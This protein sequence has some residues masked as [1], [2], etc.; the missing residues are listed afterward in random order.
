M[1]RSIKSMIDTDYFVC[2]ISIKLLVRHEL[3]GTIG[4]GKSIACTMEV[5]LPECYCLHC[6]ELVNTI[7]TKHRMQSHVSIQMYCKE[8]LNS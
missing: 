5:G 7:N 6:L 1:P 2:T 8:N 4:V 3:F